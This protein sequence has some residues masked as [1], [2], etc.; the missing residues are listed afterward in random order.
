M[1]RVS[2]QRWLKFGLFV[3]ALAAMVNLVVADHSGPLATVLI[4]ALGFISVSV[5]VRWCWSFRLFRGVSHRVWRRLRKSYR[6]WRARRWKP[7]HYIHMSRTTP[8]STSP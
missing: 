1:R 5:F 6:A 7:D 2:D 3:T 4:W 8:G